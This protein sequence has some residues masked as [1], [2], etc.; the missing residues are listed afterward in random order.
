VRVAGLYAYPLKSARA[1]PLREAH[2]DTF[3]IEGDRRWCVVG[4]DG[5]V[6]TQRDCPVLATI[7]ALPTAE[8][9]ELRCA[10]RDPLAIPFPDAGQRSVPVHVWR[11]RTEGRG[12]GPD[13]DAWL[14]DLLQR[15]ARLLYMS[16]DT[17]RQVNL[18][19][20]RPGDRVS[21]A[22]GYPLLLTSEASLAE[23]NRRL[24]APLPMNRFRPNL[25]IDGESPFSEDGWARIRVG[26]VE[27]RVVKPCARCV[28]TTTDQQTGERG[29]EPLRTLASF[30]KRDGKILFGE[31]LIHHAPGRV[32][33]GDPV[34]VLET[35]S[36][37]I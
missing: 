33:L 7:D 17:H 29:R 2:L 23:L 31:N 19:F 3:G 13:A 28:V 15:P 35:R 34:Q 18:D 32:Q 5:R 8:G 10:G 14:E 1:V 20:G 24:A 6:I 27:L 36:S 25:V 22:D 37:P 4:A 12:S 26:E 16:A 9:L 30:R 21:F 11:D